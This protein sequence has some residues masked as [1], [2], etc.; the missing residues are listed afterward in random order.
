MR[1]RN[2][3]FAVAATVAAGSAIA[4]TPA[5]AQGYHRDGYSRG[6]VGRVYDHP[7]YGYGFGYGYAAPVYDYGYG[8]GYHRHYDAYRPYWR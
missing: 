5:A 4:A 3:L 6:Y 8:Y 1:I 2:A 7:H